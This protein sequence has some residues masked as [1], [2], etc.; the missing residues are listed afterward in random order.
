MNLSCYTN[1][2]KL[3]CFEIVTNMTFFQ[4]EILQGINYHHH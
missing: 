2:F 3:G 1:V 4:I